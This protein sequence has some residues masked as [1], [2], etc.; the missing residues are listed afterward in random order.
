VGL[1]IGRGTANAEIVSPANWSVVDATHITITC[2]NTHSGTTDIEQLG[3]SHF[4]TSAVIF[5]PVNVKPSQQTTAQITF[6]GHIGVWF[7][8]PGS[9]SDTWPLSG[10]QWNA[11]Q[12]GQNGANKDL[13]LRNNNSSSS[14]QF[15][16]A[17]NTQNLFLLTESGG[18][19]QF[20]LNGNFQP[21]AITLT[22]L[23]TSATL[24]TIV[25][26][27]CG[28]S[29]ATITNAN[30][31]ASFDIGVGTAPASTG[32]TVTMPAAAHEWNCSVNDPTTISTSVF[33]Q[34][35]TTY[36]STTALFQN[37]NDVAVATAPTANDIYHV[38][39]SAN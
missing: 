7:T 15:L 31:T 29:A 22:N 28:G 36:G 1:T 12:T 5:D 32:C 19:A 35:Q 11:V 13:V 33:V 2:A 6:Q 4:E 21:N 18:F 24:P 34:K 25:A 8:A 10:F 30:G 20:V 37:F 39:C 26:G 27:G 9:T 16:N 3:A 23:L 14:F 38:T 17:A